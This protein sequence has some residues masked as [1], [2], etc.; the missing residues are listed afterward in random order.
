MVD[1]IMHVLAARTPATDI[2]GPL[3]YEL[4]SYFEEHFLTRLGAIPRKKNTKILTLKAE[5]RNMCCAWN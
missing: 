1:R 2:Y 4:L 3:R 5:L